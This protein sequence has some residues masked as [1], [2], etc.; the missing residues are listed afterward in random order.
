MDHELLIIG[1]INDGAEAEFPSTDVP[2]LA[3]YCQVLL[4]Q[5]FDRRLADQLPGWDAV[6]GDSLEEAA[7]GVA[8]RSDLLTIQ[9]YHFTRLCAWRKTGGMEMLTVR[10]DFHGC[11]LSLIS[12]KRPGGSTH[13]DEVNAA[14]GA[15]VHAEWK[16]GRVPIVGLDANAGSPTDLEAATTLTWVAPQPTSIVGF[17]VS[18][19]VLVDGVAGM[20]STG[21]HPPIVAMVR[22]PV[23]A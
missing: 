15:E 14:L 17:L 18:S 21:E 23:P 3:Q 11:P 2:H 1:T 10:A 4:G 20:K 5:E 12:M 22:V 7:L 16:A 8:V 9:G 19:R 6:Q 13:W